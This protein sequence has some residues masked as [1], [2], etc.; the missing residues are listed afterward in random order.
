M[1]RQATRLFSI[2]DDFLTRL[3]DEHNRTALEQLSQSAAYDNEVF[4]EFRALSH[5][6]QDVLTEA[7][8]REETALKEFT[9]RYGVF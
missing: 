2:Y 4:T 5:D 7:F 6:F 9:L 8:L 1:S 3:N